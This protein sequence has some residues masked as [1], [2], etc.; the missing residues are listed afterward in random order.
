MQVEAVSRIV[1]LSALRAATGAL[2][3]RDRSRAESQTAIR[4]IAANRTV[5]HPSFHPTAQ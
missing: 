1:D 4:Q 3:P 5:V 2:Q